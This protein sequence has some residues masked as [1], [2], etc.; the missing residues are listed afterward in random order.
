V[1]VRAGEITLPCSRAVEGNV[2]DPQVLAQSVFEIFRRN[3]TEHYFDLNG[4]VSRQEFWYFVLG[5]CVVSLVA[6]VVDAILHTDILVSAV[7]L[8]LLLPLAGIGAR[9]LQDTGKNG[10]AVWLAIIPMAINRVLLFLFALSDPLGLV[11]FFFQ[12]PIWSLIG[13]VTIVAV[14]WIGYL[15]AQP[16]TFGHNAFG[17]EPPSGVGSTPKAAI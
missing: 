6:A 5:S 1:G 9:R 15:C 16:G 3:V 14:L 8:A 11:G 7:G 2:M 13:L 4:R 12:W 17:P 10:S